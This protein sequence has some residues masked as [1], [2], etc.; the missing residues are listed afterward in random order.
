MILRAG[1]D[2]D[3][4]GFIALIGDAWAEYPG[5]TLDVDGEEPMLRALASYFAEVGGALWAL[6]Q[7]GAIVGMVGTKPIGNGTWELCRMYVAPSLRG[8]GAAV[9]LLE[10]AQ[11]HARAAGALRLRI[12][13]D[14]RFDRAHRFYERL[15]FVRDGGIR[16][17]FDVSN[18]LEYGYFKPLADVVV[19][20]LD[21]AATA[22]A[23]R[24]L[25]RVLR[26]CVEAGAS[27]SF[28]PP[29][30]LKDAEGFYRRRATEVAAGKRIVLAAW[31]DGSLV[32]TAM[33]DLDMP[34][35]QQHRAEIQKLLVHPMARRYGV[36]RTLMLQAEQ[37]ALTAGRSLLT[38]D[39]RAGDAAE[40]LYRSMAWTE[41]GRIPAFARNAAGGL[42]ATVLFYKHIR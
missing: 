33:V 13:T 20:A 26:E 6:E 25:G 18:S 21:T 12:W 31:K 9:T 29:L 30:S 22:S 37:A 38:L 10:T 23:A 24:A 32:G 15:G 39:T 40:E 5:V 16:P 17:L 36:A 4:A 1:K 28:L 3:A 35:N 41:A 11:T 19:C 14:T 7:D 27:V 2:T 34:A 42:D 8:S